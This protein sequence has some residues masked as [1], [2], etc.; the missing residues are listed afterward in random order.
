MVV[1]FRIVD[2]VVGDADGES[3]LL[4]ILL[5]LPIETATAILKAVTDENTIR[6][7]A[8]LKLASIPI[9]L[10]VVLSHLLF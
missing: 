8:S 3:I 1:E 6:P 7:V 5:L 10:R 2:V 4:L 9:V